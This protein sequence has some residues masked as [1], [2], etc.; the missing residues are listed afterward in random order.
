MSTRKKTVRINNLLI[1]LLIIGL[2]VMCGVFGWNLHQL[3]TKGAQEAETS[4]V[5][6]VV[7]H[8]TNTAYEQGN[9]PTELDDSLFQ[10]LTDALTANDPEAVSSAVMKCFVSE[11][12]TWVNKDGN[13][14][15]GGM[16]YISP[17]RRDDF[18]KYTL[19]SFYSDMDLYLTQ[20]G[21]DGLMQVSEVSVLSNTAS[22]P[23]TVLVTPATDEEEAE[24]QTF[25]SRTV[26]ASWKY[27][28]TGMP[29]SDLMSEA[30]FTLINDNGRWEIVAIQPVGG[31][32]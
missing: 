2:I 8:K 5:E 24:T 17:I 23:F 25:D 11:Y 15:I 6:P 19:N 7:E 26:Q 32:E 21:E 10:E 9:N 16:S 4:T 1:V 20:Y 27:T 30:V 31:A 14:D 28:S 12:F 3:R 29:T 22:D 13:Y 18:E